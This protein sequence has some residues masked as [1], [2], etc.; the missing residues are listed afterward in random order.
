MD[1]D[2]G[3]YIDHTCILISHRMPSSDADSINI[4]LETGVLSLAVQQTIFQQSTE[5]NA[6]TYTPLGFLASSSAING[7]PINSLHWE[8]HIDSAG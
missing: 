5:S 1:R 7:D 2:F 3:G 4:S 8:M 6:K